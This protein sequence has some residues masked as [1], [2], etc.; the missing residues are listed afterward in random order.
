LSYILTKILELIKGKTP[1]PTN[2]PII[3][4]DKY[5]YGDIY[6]KRYI[7][8]LLETLDDYKIYIL[9]AMGVVAIGILTYT[10][11]DSIKNLS[12]R[13]GNDGDATELPDIPSP[14]PSDPSS[15]RDTAFYPEGYLQTFSRK[16]GDLTAKVKTR[17]GE[18]Y[19]FI[20]RDGTTSDTTNISSNVGIPT[21]LYRE[22]NQ[23]MW[24]GLP[25]PRVE[26]YN[27]V[28]YYISLDK[29][30]YINI[31]DSTMN[32]D[33]IDII[34]PISGNSIGVS[35]LGMG[36]KFDFMRQSFT[37]FKSTAL[38]DSVIFTKKNTNI[39]IGRPSASSLDIPQES[40]PDF[41]KSSPIP[42][43]SNKGKERA[44]DNFD[45]IPLGPPII[46]QDTEN[47]SDNCRTPTPRNRELPEYIDMDNF[48]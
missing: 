23:L 3:M 34:N 8:N 47:W 26:N 36:S 25:I 18:L 41:E 15:G 4:P 21:G 42:I 10:Y 12:T 43:P 44:F 33:Y 30:N 20:R 1:D 16:L 22:G 9:I 5:K 32:Y 28:D 46:N 38:E 37:W 31:I 2:E 17:A 27:G 6:N 14:I 24:K 11:W 13:G 19:S 40:L 45:D 39:F 35:P 48:S 29:D 7:D